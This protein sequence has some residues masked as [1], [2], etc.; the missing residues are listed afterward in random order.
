[1]ANCS[2]CD[3]TGKCQHDFHTGIFGDEDDSPTI[4]DIV[5]L[6]E[7]P[8]CGDDNMEWP[9]DCPHCGGTGDD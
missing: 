5:F 7:C 3:G 8:N 9:G 6:S 4:M 2:H 1:M